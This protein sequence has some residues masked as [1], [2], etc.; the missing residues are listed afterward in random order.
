MLG[1]REGGREGGGGEHNLIKFWRFSKYMYY[2]SPNQDPKH[3]VFYKFHGTKKQ[4]LS[5]CMILYILNFNLIS[6]LT[7]KFQSNI[8]IELSIGAS[9]LP[10]ACGNSARN[11][12]RESVTWSDNN[13][14]LST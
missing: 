9:I 5:T 3:V 13:Y 2:Y 11:F 4:N 1:G 8:S 6:L 10:S 7:S 12:E 14:K